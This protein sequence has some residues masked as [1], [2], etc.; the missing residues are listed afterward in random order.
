MANHAGRDNKGSLSLAASGIG[1][2]MR[3]RATTRG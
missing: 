1:H 3:V 2:F